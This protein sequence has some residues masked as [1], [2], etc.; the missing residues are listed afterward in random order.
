MV[1]YAPY[2][3]GVDAID[4]PT[5]SKDAEGQVMDYSLQLW[6]VHRGIPTSPY[7]D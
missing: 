3:G 1:R 6:G 2:L 7:S 4:F 5:T